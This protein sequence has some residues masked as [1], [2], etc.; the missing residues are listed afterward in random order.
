MQTVTWSIYTNTA[1]GF[2]N[3]NGHLIGSAAGGVSKLQGDIS[4]LWEE[5]GGTYTDFSDANTYAK[6]VKFNKPVNLGQ[7]GQRVTGTSPIIFLTG[8]TDSWH[9]NKGTGGGFIENGALTTAPTSP[10]S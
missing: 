4:D 6:F 2:G 5:H 10:S 7:Q 8:V 3:A 9:T 1:L